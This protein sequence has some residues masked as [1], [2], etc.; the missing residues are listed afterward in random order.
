VLGQVLPALTCSLSYTRGHNADYATAVV[1]PTNPNTK[2]IRKIKAFPDK[3]TVT[4]YAKRWN[5]WGCVYVGGHAG[6]DWSLGKSFFGYTLNTK[7]ENPAPVTSKLKIPK[8]PSLIQLR[9]YWNVKRHLPVIQGQIGGGHG[10]THTLEPA[11]C[12]C[13]IPKMELVLTVGKPTNWRSIWPPT[14]ILFGS[15]DKS[16]QRKEAWEQ[17]LDTDSRRDQFI[18]SLSPM[19]R[20]EYYNTHM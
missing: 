11:S 8:A 2:W 19:D 16:L 20:L 6:W 7:W 14:K 4:V 9:P 18:Q 13:K 12:H 17:S 3:Q 1:K 15:K 10:E 5:L